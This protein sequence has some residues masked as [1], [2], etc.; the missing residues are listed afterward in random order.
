MRNQRKILIDQLD[1]KLKHFQMAS[2]VIV[3]SGGWIKTIRTTLNM[4]LEQLGK[5]LNITKQGVKSI[6]D[7][8]VKGTIT[9]NSLKEA[10]DAL[11]MKFVYGFVPNDGSIQELIDIKT[12]ELAR[13]IVLRT[14]QSMKLE[15]QGIGQEKINESIKNLADEIKREMRKS[16]WD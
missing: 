9:I 10:G 5:K 7:S 2:T 4:T 3:P 16:L 12:V 1:Q 8:E 15:D 11:G 6:E 13:K 14:D